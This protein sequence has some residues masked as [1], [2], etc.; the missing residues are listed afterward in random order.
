MHQATREKLWSAL[1]LVLLAITSKD[2]HANP[3][4][5][6]DACVPWVAADDKHTGALTWPGCTGCIKEEILASIRHNG[7][8]S[9]ELLH[10]CCTRYPRPGGEQM[11][12]TAAARYLWDKMR[13]IR[14]PQRGLSNERLSV[15]SFNSDY[16]KFL[17][18]EREIQ[19]FGGMLFLVFAV[20]PP[21]DPCNFSRT[22]SPKRVLPVAANTR[23]PSRRV[24][25]C[26]TS[27]ISHATS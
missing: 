19:C 1:N 7:W 6:R 14:C 23:G 22:S 5:Y 9:D 12:K 3:N 16:E 13:T 18:E 15:D 26:T 2:E 21:S 4:S 27:Y 8:T 10:G 17:S 24:Q 25:Q 20:A 11:T